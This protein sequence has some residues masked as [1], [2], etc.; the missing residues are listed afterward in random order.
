MSPDSNPGTTSARQAATAAPLLVIVFLAATFLS[1][2]LI[3][4]VQ[5]MFARFVL[6]RLGGSPGVWSVAMAFFQAVLFAGYLY[7][8]LLTRYAPWTVR[9]GAQLLVSAAA[10]VWLP[11]GIAAGWGDPPADGEALWLLGLFAASIGV[12][13]FALSANGP[14]M[15][16]WF[17]RATRPGTDPYFLYAVSNAGSFLA[18]I[19]YPLLLEPLLPLQAQSRLW[20]VGFVVLVLLLAICGALA[21]RQPADA[22]P[23]AAASSERPAVRQLLQWC[24]LAAVPSGLLVAV[25]AQISTDIAAIPLV[26]I[27]PLSLYLLSFVVVFGRWGARG[28][29]I[30]VGITP[31]ALLL[32]AAVMALWPEANVEG[33]GFLAELALHVV[34]FVLVA[35]MC[36]GELASRRPHADDLTLFYL[37]MSFGGMIGGA[38]ASLLAPSLFNW[39]AEYPILIV[40]AALCRPGGSQPL[41]ANRRA[42]LLIAGAVAVGVLAP[43]LAGYRGLGAWPMMATVVYAGLLLVAA[44]SW[45]SVW[46]FAAALAVVLAAS[47]LYP[48]EGASRVTLR[49]FFGVHKIHDSEDGQFRL[50]QHGTTIH[51]AQRIRDAEGRRL[52]GPPEPLTY[53]FRGSPMHEV[54]E[55]MRKAKKGPVR[56]GVVG[57]GAGSMACLMEAGDE[58]RYFEIDMTV[59][60]IA[61]D[62]R[63]FTFLSSC[64]PQA[65]IVV[66]DARLTLAREAD[67]AFDVLFIDAFASDSVPTHLLTREAV[68][69]YASKLAPGGIVAMH[70]SNRHM[71]LKGVGHAVAKAAGLVSLGKEGDL[72]E[73]DIDAY[74]FDTT[75]VVAARAEADLA[76]LTE[77]AEWEKPD[78]DELAIR[79]WTDDYANPLG[80]IWRSMTAKEE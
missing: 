51:G 49:S 38:F 73:D 10:I 52:T 13:Y 1:A 47:R 7:A 28:H 43:G 39:I 29:G 27:V 72:P 60:A 36:H 20:S 17:A 59:I 23:G 4:A 3:F 14:L 76:G 41:W 12:P 31:W 24:F 68:A 79:P 34:V 74:R 8:H 37:A 80:A 67:G 42:V 64:R 30:V 48:P 5:P 69:L 65:P 15:Q 35:L 61:K 19:A 26:W 21:L 22:L 63:Y 62:P 70:L 58:I 53:Y 46:L 55:A 44:L 78:A 6:P 18:L 56:I 32:L 57:L 45:R 40:A 50:L 9:V 54:L 66:G 25:T 75:L 71:D 11:L 16:S 33:E 2:A 77:D